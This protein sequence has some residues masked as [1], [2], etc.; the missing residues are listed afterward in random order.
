[1]REGMRLREKR[2]RTLLAPRRA[3]DRQNVMGYLQAVYYIL[4]AW[5]R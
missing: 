1:M 3:W 5:Q 2:K 4:Q